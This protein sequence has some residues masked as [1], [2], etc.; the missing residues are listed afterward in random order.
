MPR[1]TE[2]LNCAIY[3]RKSSEEGLEQNFNSLDAQREACEAYIESQRQEGWRL[4]RKAYDDGGI[5]GG[6][7]K[8]PGLQ[9]LLDDIRD[10]K[11]DV[12]L[13]Y[14][15][16]RLTRSLAD[17][18]RMVE[19]FEVR[20]NADDHALSAAEIVAAAAGAEVLVPTVTDASDAGL[21][22]A[23]PDSKQIVLD[24]IRM[25]EDDH[26]VTVA[27]KTKTREV[28]NDL[29]EK[30]NALGSAEGAPFRFRA[31]IRGSRKPKEDEDY[32]YDQNVEIEVRRA[33]KSPGRHRAGA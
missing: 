13:V 6:T 29:I 2:T 17:F 4:V 30:I 25:Y 1:D 31:R 9:S 32:P 24:E 28:A 26:K 27:T 16:D 19:L 8:R 14:K 7:M 3:T 21:I 15:V 22:A 20:L 33:V 18:A 5:S 11:V 10:G 23:L 12:V